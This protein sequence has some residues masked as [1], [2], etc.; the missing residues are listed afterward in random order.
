M[1]YTV[2]ALPFDDFP[3]V[4]HFSIYYAQSI[5]A[6]KLNKVTFT[7]VSGTVSAVAL[8]RNFKYSSQF[9]HG[10]EKGAK[11]NVHLEK[12]DKRH[13]F[14][15]VSASSFTYRASKLSANQ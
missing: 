6:Q 12:R 9:K 1:E 13:D 5:F 2:R 8:F 3:F 15:I 7:T 11:K 10:G 4:I 14:D